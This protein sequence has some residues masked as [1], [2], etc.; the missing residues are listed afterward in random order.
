MTDTNRHWNY[1]F[2][3]GKNCISMINCEVVS[4]LSQ[5][6]FNKK[7]NAFTKLL[8]NVDSTSPF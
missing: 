5:H 6:L 8:N 1:V 2:F 3:T 4:M 7:F